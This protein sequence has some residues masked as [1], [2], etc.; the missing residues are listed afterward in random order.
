MLGGRVEGKEGK[1][2]KSS[3]KKAGRI[4]EWWVQG[5]GVVVGVRV[6]K[7]RRKGCVRER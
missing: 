1:G 2:V 6:W 7:R 4:W 3:G 5:L